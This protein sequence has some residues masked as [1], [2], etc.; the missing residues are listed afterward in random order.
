MSLE[1]NNHTKI[2][3]NSS[4]S[5][6]IIE[7]SRSTMKWIFFNNFRLVQT[8]FIN[9]IVQLSFCFERQLLCISP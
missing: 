5:A 3:Q 4:N 9:R 7:Y 2:V 1:L 8:D 6:W